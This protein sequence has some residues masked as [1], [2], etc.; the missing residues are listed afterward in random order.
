MEPIMIL[1]LS[2]S[3]IGILIIFGISHI[4]IENNASSSFDNKS[5]HFDFFMTRVKS[6]SSK[7]RRLYRFIFYFQNR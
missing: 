6:N 2:I 7:V 3:L 4:K 1:L 5:N